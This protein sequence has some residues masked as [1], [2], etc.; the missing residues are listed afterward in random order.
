M[1]ASLPLELQDAVT[2]QL[3]DHLVACVPFRPRTSAAP[4]EEAARRVAWDGEQWVY[5]MHDGRV[6]T[7][8]PLLL[9]P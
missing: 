3:S 9:P 2:A 8:P 4:E 5:L 1:F 7:L 6:L